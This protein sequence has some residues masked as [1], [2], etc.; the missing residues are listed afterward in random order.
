MSPVRQFLF[1]FMAVLAVTFAQVGPAQ[2]ASTKKT[3]KASTSYKSAKP[4][5]RVKATIKA[6]R[7]RAAAIPDFRADGT[8]NLRSS[9]VMVQDQSSGA[10][11]LEKNSDAVV[12]IASITKLMTAMVVLDA[13]PGLDEMLTISTEDVDTLKNTRSRLAV[14]TQLSR[15]DMLRLA[16]MSSENRAASALSRHY[17]GGSA[18]FI[19]AMNHKAHEL[20]LVDTRFFDSTGLNSGN[21]SSARDLVKMV[22]ASSRYPLIREFTTTTDYEVTLNSRTRRYVNTNALV[23]SPDWQIAVSK[24]GFTNEAG[25]CLVMQAWVNERPLVI[26]LMDSW[27]KLTRLGDANRI[28]KW[29]E[30]AAAQSLGGTI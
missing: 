25:K 17:P 1:L 30:S 5:T 27:G 26:V 10:V 22:A 15:E 24:T 11:L 6:R 21:V 18:A 29:I 19:A 20:G 16:L 4:R 14:G 9:A 28:K 12:P 3:A 7:K 2:A 13:H 8:P 23:S